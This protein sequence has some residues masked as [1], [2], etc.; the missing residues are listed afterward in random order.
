MDIVQKSTSNINL[1]EEEMRK[2]GY[3]KIDKINCI[4]E[5]V[6]SFINEGAYFVSVNNDLQ[7]NWKVTLNGEPQFVKGLFV[8]PKGI[9]NIKKV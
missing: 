6:K 3:I 1:N 4:L 8:I 2:A 9:N 5:D 7:G